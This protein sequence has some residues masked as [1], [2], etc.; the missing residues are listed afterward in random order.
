[1]EDYLNPEELLSIA[2]FQKSGDTDGLLAPDLTNLSQYW[3][4]LITKI[5]M[6]FNQNFLYLEF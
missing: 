2:E 1:M 5:I 4:R 6:V 3:Y